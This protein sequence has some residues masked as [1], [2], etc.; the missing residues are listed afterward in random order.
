MWFEFFWTDEIEEHLAEH[1]LTREDF[2]HVV[3]QSWETQSVSRSSGR[4]LAMGYTEDGRYIVCV[5]EWIDDITIEPYTAYEV[6]E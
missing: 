5:W 2:E 6:G 4:P 3:S 1:G